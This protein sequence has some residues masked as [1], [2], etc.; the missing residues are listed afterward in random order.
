MTI[1]MTMDA[2]SPT[3]IRA[4]S[5]RKGTAD[6][7]VLLPARVDSPD[8]QGFS[9]VRRAEYDILD[10]LSANDPRGPERVR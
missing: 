1:S 3:T 10:T 5:G 6:G 8:E 4:L 9:S 2:T 7:I